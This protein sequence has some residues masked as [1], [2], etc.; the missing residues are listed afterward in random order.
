MFQQFS[1]SVDVVGPSE[2]GG[3]SSL[4]GQKRVKKWFMLQIWRL[5]QVA[6]L[7]TLILLALNLSLQAWGY[8]KWRSGF[9]ANPYTGVLSILFALAL[10]IWIFA[11]IWDR[12]LKM[13]RE[14]T[15]VL[16]EKNPYLK[17]RFAPK[18][19][20]LTAMTWVPLMEYIGKND[21]VL[22]AN[23]EA[24]KDWLKRELKADDLSPKELEDILSY[25]GKERK[26]LFGL[27]EK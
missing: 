23:A 15:S 17:E 19:V 8:V 11:Y 2:S 9:L 24:L 13:W 1:Y 6:Q 7:L 14:Q 26:D 12:R 5:Q 27:E 16:V 4:E 22:K 18:E 25:M 20:A 10:A 3:E 21:P